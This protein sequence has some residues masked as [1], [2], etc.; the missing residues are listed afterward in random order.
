LKGEKWTKVQK[1]APTK[2]HSKPHSKGIPTGSTAPSSENPQVDGTTTILQKNPSFNPFDHLG[3]QEDPPVINQE[4]DQ[5]TPL[6]TIEGNNEKNP[7][8]PIVFQVEGSSSHIRRHDK[9]ETPR[10]IR[11]IR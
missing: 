7:R 11:L 9:E 3:S 1:Q 5:Q 8:T 6:P 4:V 10:D 2:K